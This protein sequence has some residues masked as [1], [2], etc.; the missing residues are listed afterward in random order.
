MAK[1]HL[2]TAP[3]VSVATC[4]AD[5]LFWARRKF[6]PIP[7]GWFV[8]SDA[9]HRQGT[10]Q[11]DTD[12]T[13]RSRIGLASKASRQRRYRLRKLAQDAKWDHS[14]RWARRQNAAQRL[15]SEA[16]HILGR[17]VEGVPIAL[18]A[19]E[20]G[21][22]QQAIHDLRMAH[23]CPSPTEIRSRQWAVLNWYY[24]H[25]GYSQ[26]EIARRLGTA[27][28]TVRTFPKLDIPFPTGL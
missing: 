17:I 3:G 19:E 20:F 1:W 10:I 8:V 5:D 23:G 22:S 6:S 27:R 13:V 28:L 9:V 4:E 14:R 12:T 26:S 24:S 2:C 7:K 16:G 15:R 21:V 25:L 11:R 18:V